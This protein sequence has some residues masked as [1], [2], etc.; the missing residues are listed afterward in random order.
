ML[1]QKSHGGAPTR[2]W[3]VE[4]LA[5]SMARMP[6]RLFIS[7]V[8]FTP[9]QRR[10]RGGR[11]VKL[12][13]GKVTVGLCRE[14]A[15]H[16][17]ATHCPTVQCMW[18]VHPACLQPD[19]KPATLCPVKRFTLGVSFAA[20]GMA[21]AAEA[22]G[23]RLLQ[24]AVGEDGMLLW[25]GVEGALTR[26]SGVEGMRSVRAQVSCGSAADAGAGQPHRGCLPTDLQ[27]HLESQSAAQQ[28][29]GHN[30]RRARSGCPAQGALAAAR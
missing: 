10:P 29:L 26:H 9:P 3:G 22:L 15:T 18:A 25:T 27:T 5:P 24:A 7:W 12:A 30:F 14:H 16:A 20:N 23:K 4:R 2:P 21:A 8:V 17:S 11:R 6:L 28:G 13:S 1:A 19:P